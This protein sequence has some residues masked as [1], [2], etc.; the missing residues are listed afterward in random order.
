MNTREQIE[1]PEVDPPGLPDDVEGPK[2]R[3][4]G[5]EPGDAIPS[6]AIET[7]KKG[8]SKL[9]VGSKRAPTAPPSRQA[10]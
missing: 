8:S 2:E 10:V 4:A 9:L 7:L 1:V 6:Q 5:P 3:C